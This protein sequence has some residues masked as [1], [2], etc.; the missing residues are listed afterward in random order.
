MAKDKGNHGHP[1]TA[2]AWQWEAAEAVVKAQ[3]ARQAK[4]R[5]SII[6]ERESRGLKDAEARSRAGFRDDVGGWDAGKRG[7]LAGR[8]SYRGQSEWAAEDKA[9]ARHL[10]ARHM[11]R[12]VDKVADEM[13]KKK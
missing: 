4:S 7:A 2:K 12:V 8:A 13:S 11:K 1:L 3:G 10:E 6:A 9:R 5:A